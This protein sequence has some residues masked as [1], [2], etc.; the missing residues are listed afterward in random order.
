MLPYEAKEELFAESISAA[1]NLPDM[2][3]LKLREYAR[4]ACR[5][6]FD[7]D[8]QAEKLENW[9]CRQFDAVYPF[10]E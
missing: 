8:I 6:S 10:R 1:I 4:E 2:E 3:L 5:E 7:I 9:L